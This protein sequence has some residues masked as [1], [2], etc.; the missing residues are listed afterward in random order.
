MANTQE[1]PVHAIKHY[2]WSPDL[3]DV[4][5]PVCTTRPDGNDEGTAGES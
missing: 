5:E 1:P 4:P 3:P 2:G